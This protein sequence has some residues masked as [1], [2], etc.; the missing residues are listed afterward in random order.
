MADVHVSG[1]AFREE[2]KLIYLL[3]KPKYFIPVHGEIRHLKQH[4]EMI[5]DLGHNPKHMLMPQI[6]NKIEVCSKFLKRSDNV[7]AGN[8]LVDGAGIGDVGAE[9]LRDRRRL[10]EDGMLLVIM[11]IEQGGTVSSV[12]VITRGF[13]YAR[14]SID[15]I[16][17]IKQSFH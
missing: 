13:I 15:L 5:A 3:I 10:S 16:E 8:V 11:G 17:E 9:V 12:D 4:M 1:H 2:L 6:S 14:E 7:T